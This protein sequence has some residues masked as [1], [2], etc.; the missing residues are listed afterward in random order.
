MKFRDITNS[1]IELQKR[2]LFVALWTPPNEPAHPFSVLESPHIKEYFS[3][4]GQQGDTGFFAFNEQ[5]EATGII[6]LRYKSSPSKAYA[7]YPELAIAV[8]VEFRRQG[9]AFALLSEM[10]QRTKHL[11]T[12][13][14]LGV[15]PKNSSAI[16]LYKKF[17]FA[18]YETAPSSYLQMVRKNSG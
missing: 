12:G 9:I 1:D 4:W 3:D 15:H 18:I 11:A 17:N 5:N 2:L 6:Q 8:N 7:N 10:L 16:A 13:I 14:R